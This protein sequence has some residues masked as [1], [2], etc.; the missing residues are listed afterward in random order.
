MTARFPLDSGA[1]VE[2]F[3]DQLQAG[4]GL[5]QVGKDGVRRIL[6]PRDGSSDFVLFEDKTL[7]YVRSKLG[8]PAIYA[9]PDSRFEPPAQ[10]VLM[11]LDGTT[12]HSER[13]WVWIIE[14]TTS[15]LLGDPGFRLAEEDFI[16]VSGHSVSEHLGYCIRR[17]APQRTVEEARQVYLQT[18]RR[19]MAEI[20][21]G[22]GH[23]DAFQ[24][25]PGL[26][27]FLL[28]LKRRGVKVALVTSGLYEKAWPEVVSAFRQLD[29]GDPHDFYD[30]IITAGTPFGKGQVGTLGEL[31]P[32]PHPW[33]YAEAARVGLGIEPSQRHRVIG[34]EDSA[35]GLLSLTLAGFRV[36]GVQ[37]GTIAQAGLSGLLWAS[38]DHFEEVVPL[39]CG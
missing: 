28:E 16:H 17:Y 19:E 21:A 34:I 27:P 2:G 32:K 15:S 37:G 39:I 30:A 33:L 38:V 24:P 26:K 35:A 23:P 18:S 6:S 7:V 1:P 36:I 9:L 14:Q 13:F 5:F 10:A 12:V 4:E 11:D 25:A 31:S 29:L 22:R 3:S 20:L 8:H